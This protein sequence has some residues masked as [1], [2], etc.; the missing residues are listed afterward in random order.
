[1]DIKT[2]DFALDTVIKHNETFIK[3][4]TGRLVEPG[5][6]FVLDQY[7]LILTDLKDKKEDLRLENLDRA[8]FEEKKKAEKK[9]KKSTKKKAKTCELKDDK[10]DEEAK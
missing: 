1:M 9:S 4:H 7:K 10:K 5:V 8:K 6:K 2:L 3:N